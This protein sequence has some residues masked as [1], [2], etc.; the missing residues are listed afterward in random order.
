MKT[1]ENEQLK[2]LPYFV[3]THGSKRAS[4]KYEW[5]VYR[6]K[7]IFKIIASTSIFKKKNRK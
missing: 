1:F 2:Y 7:S 4:H 3:D 6:A 5:F